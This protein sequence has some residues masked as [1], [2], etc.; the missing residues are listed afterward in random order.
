MAVE[1]EVIREK[2]VDQLYANKDIVRST[3]TSA[4]TASVLTD[5]QL[6]KGMFE[7]NDFIGAYLLFSSG[8]TD[9]GSNV[10]DN[11]LSS[12]ATTVNVTSGGDFAADEYISI[13]SEWMSVT[14][15]ST[16][17]LTVVRAILGTTAA[18]HT[19]D[20]DVYQTC[21][22]QAAKIIAYDRVDGKFTLSPDFRSTIDNS[23]D[24]EIHYDLH[25]FRVNEAIIW[26]IEVGSRNALSAPDTDAETTTLDVE[27][28][29]EG[30]LS[31]CKFAIA[32]QTEAR[33]PAAIQPDVDKAELMRQAVIHESNWLRGMSLAGYRPFVVARRVQEEETVEG[34]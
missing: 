24:Y 11:P 15:I 30:A 33:D 22:M 31:F 14:S 7:A 1:R 3:T 12:G 34:G 8:N 27:T 10:T 19:Q 6:K 29:V 25:P 4:G 32:N 21:D 9:S 5:I 18:S 2:I 17:E 20:T 16:N 13:D 28:I 26:A 23:A